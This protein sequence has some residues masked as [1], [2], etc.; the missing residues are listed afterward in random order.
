MFALK[1]TSDRQVISDASNASNAFARDWPAFS[2]GSDPDIF[3]DAFCAWH[4]SEECIGCMG[5]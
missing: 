2:L 5:R 1:I 4:A 3:G